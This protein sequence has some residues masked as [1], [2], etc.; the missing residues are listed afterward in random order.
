MVV[1]AR[2]VKDVDGGTLA[3]I[4]RAGTVRRVGAHRR[5]D[6]EDLEHVR[7]LSWQWDSAEGD[8]HT[9]LKVRC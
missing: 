7:T 1:V 9:D 5:W 8:I 4:S 6:R 2:S 3:G